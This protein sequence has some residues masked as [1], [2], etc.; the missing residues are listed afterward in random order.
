MRKFVV[1]TSFGD[2]ENI[3]RPTFGS[4]LK[5]KHWLLSTLNGSFKCLT[6]GYIF[7]ES[8]TPAACSKAQVMDPVD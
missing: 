5:V 1:L 4:V 3:Y 6:L 2:W 8:C 7:Y